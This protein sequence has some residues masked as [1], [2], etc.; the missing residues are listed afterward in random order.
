LSGFGHDWLALR[1]PYDQVA[2]SSTLADRFA[3]ALGPAPRVIDFGCGTGA[4]LRYLAPRVASSLRQEQH[5]LCLDSDRDL[6]ARAEAM[7]GRWRKE[8]RREVGWQGSMRFQLLDLATGLD[9]LALDG[10]GVTASALLDLTSA[11][12]LDTLAERCRRAPV[13]MA[14]SFDGR[15][16]WQPA[17]VED[18]LVLARFLAHQ[19]TDK[20]FGPALGPDAISHLAGRLGADGRRVTTATSDWRLVPA[21]RPLLEAM[22]EGVIAAAAAIQDDRRLAGWA[23]QRRRLLA[24]G[25]LGLTVGHLDLLALPESA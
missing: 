24:R 16:S 21:D 1:E 19:R 13:L 8:G 7:L 25:E 15:L 10:V 2:R 22:L 4:N 11:V 20:G 23:A 12:W 18:D 17:L 9:A 14:L 3:S 5:W 6:L